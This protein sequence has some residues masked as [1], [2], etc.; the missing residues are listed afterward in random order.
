[1]THMAVKCI[2]PAVESQLEYPVHMQPVIGPFSEPYSLQIAQIGSKRCL[3]TSVNVWRGAWAAH[4]LL[5]ATINRFI[6]FEAPQEQ[7]ECY[8]LEYRLIGLS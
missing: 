1:M 2:I 3:N 4:Q 7:I 8:Q 5:T 6:R